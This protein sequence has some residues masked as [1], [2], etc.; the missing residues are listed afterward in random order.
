[1]KHP[2]GVEIDDY[3]FTI[4]AMRNVGH[5]D[6]L[7]VLAV[8]V[9]QVFYLLY[10]KDEKRYIIVPGKQLVAWVDNVED[11]EEYN[12]CEEVSFV[13]DAK[14]I[15]IVE[16]KISYSNLIPYTRTDGEVKLVHI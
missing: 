5:K 12:Q 8:A 16:T 2:H 1:V 15:N 14:R 11:E 6:E 7:W 4:V 9:A 3:E 13:V 10:P